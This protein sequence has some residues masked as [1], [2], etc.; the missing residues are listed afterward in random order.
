V[1]PMPRVACAVALCLVVAG[2]GGLQVP[3]YSTAV[4][5]PTFPQPQ[6][7]PAPSPAERPAELPPPPTENSAFVTVAGVPQYVIGPGDLLELAVTRGPTQEKLQTV[8]R[9]TGIVNVLLAEVKVDGLTTD[10]AATAIAKEL[11]VFFRRAT[12]DVQVKEYN[13][14]KVTVFG[15]V[16]PQAKASANTIPLTGRVTLM[17]AIAKA[18]GFHQN[19]SLDRIRVN[20]A[21]GKT[22]TVNVFRFIQDGDLSQEF[23][24]DAGDAVFVPEQ[25]KGEERRVYLLGEVKTP[26]PAPFFPNLTLAQLIA[27]VGG[28]TDAALYDQAAIIRSAAGVTEILTVDLRRLLL[29]G[30][31]RIDQYLKPNDVVFVPRTP[32]ANWNAFIGQI[33]PT[34]DL[35]NQPL[36]TILS[37]KAIQSF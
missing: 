5:A 20:R 32:I 24:L 34:F 29:E 14:K 18:G 16:G 15:A 2:C 8:V 27:Q 12:V 25:V 23:V 21:P 10:Q 1:K 37:I 31:K 3:S 19:A 26:G 30:E 22:Y 4:N 9:P 28:W 7:A 11:S 6:A 36:Y 17:D 35:I 33:R 13:S